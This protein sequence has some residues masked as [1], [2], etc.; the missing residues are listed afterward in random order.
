M[1]LEELTKEYTVLSK[2]YNLPSFKEI[3]ENFEIDKIDRKTETLLRL[4]RKIMMEKI[5]NSLQFLDLL[6]NPVNAPRIYQKY[7]KNM[8]AED[9]DDLEKIYSNFGDLSIQSL[10]LEIDYSEQKEAETILKISAAWNS[11]KPTFRK[12]LSVFNRAEKAESKKEK[13]YFG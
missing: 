12:V 4:I 7:I 5:V 11:M 13:S 8:N 1:E 6:L 9:K 3:N 10:S 2:K